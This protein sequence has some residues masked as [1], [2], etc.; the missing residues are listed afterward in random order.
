MTHTVYKLKACGIVAEDSYQLPC[1][2][3]LKINGVTAG[4][5]DKGNTKLE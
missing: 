3:K 1:R 4:A 2:V 5:T